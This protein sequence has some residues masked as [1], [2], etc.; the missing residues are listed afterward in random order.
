MKSDC[1]CEAE[2][3]DYGWMTLV[4]VA[5]TSSTSRT[6]SCVHITVMSSAA[7]WENHAIFSA[8]SSSQPP[9]GRTGS[10]G[11]SRGVWNIY[12]VLTQ[13]KTRD[14]MISISD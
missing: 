11:D 1:Q 3:G 12:M 4:A 5:M 9:V 14:K 7:V 10:A 13:M 2:V 6:G 8:M